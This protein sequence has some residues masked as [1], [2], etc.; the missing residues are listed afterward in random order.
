MIILLS[1]ISYLLRMGELASLLIARRM[2][3][4]VFP[5]SGSPLPPPLASRDRPKTKDATKGWGGSWSRGGTR[6]QSRLC[7]AN[8]PPLVLIPIP[9]FLVLM[10]TRT[11]QD[12]HGVYERG[13]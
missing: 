13:T 9:S 11:F 10:E 8:P 5:L 6:S 1:Y 3:Q 4:S 7:T 2:S 12:S